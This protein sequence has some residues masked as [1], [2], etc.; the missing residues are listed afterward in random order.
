VGSF[1][2]YCVQSQI[3]YVATFLQQFVASENNLC[4]LFAASAACQLHTQLHNGV[5]LYAQRVTFFALL[6]VFFSD[7][8]LNNW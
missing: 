8:D 1:S 4:P 5:D 3:N 6:F 7:T 2:Y